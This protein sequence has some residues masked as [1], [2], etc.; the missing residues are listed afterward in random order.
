[1]I[2]KPWMRCDCLKASRADSPI[3]PAKQQEVPFLS[4][5]PQNSFEKCERKYE[6]DENSVR[7]DDF[8]VPRLW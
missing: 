4:P 5:E 3:N 8:Q 6:V 7:I 2:L 1:M